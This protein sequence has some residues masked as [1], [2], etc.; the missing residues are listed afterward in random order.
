FHPAA[1]F[2]QWRE[3]AFLPFGDL[4]GDGITDT[5]AGSTAPNP[6]ATD[7]IASHA[8]GPFLDQGFPRAAAPASDPP[9]S[10]TAIA[11]SGRD[12]H[13]IWKTELDPHRI[14]YER[15]HGQGY[16]LTAHPLPAGDLDGDGTP[17]VI[18][19]KHAVRP[20][21][22]EIKP[23][24]TLPLQVLS[25]RTGRRLW[26]AGPLPLGFEAYGYSHIFWVKSLAITPND[27]P[28]LLV[29]HRSPFLPS[30]PLTTPGGGPTMP[31]LARVSGRDG[32]ILWDLALS[33]H[34]DP[35]NMGQLPPPGVGDLDGDG[36]LDVVVPLQGSPGTGRPDH[37]LKAVALRDGRLLWSHRLDYKTS[38]MT[39]PQ[40]AVADLDGDT[41]AEVLVTEQ[42]AAG[43]QAALG[44]KAL[45][46]RDGEVRW[47]WKGTP[48]IPNQVWGWL[49]LADFQ[50]N[51]RHTPCLGFSDPND[52]K[53]V[54]RILVFDA[55]GEVSVHRD[56]S[57]NSSGPGSPG[58]SVT[59]LRAVDLTGDRRD[60][61]LLT[62][63]DRLHV[64]GRD[65]KELWSRPQK[66]NTRV[67]QILPASSGQAGTVI[68]SPAVGLDGADGHPRWAGHSP[69]SWWWSHFKPG[70]LDP[71][72]SSRPPLLIAQGLGTT[73][74]R[75]A[76]STTPKGDFASPRG[77][78]VPPG[79]ARDDPRWTRPL[80]WTN[81]VAREAV[82]PGLLA[83]VA[84]ALLNVG[85][86]LV[87]LRLAA[88]R[89][90]WTLRLLMA[91]PVAAAIPLTAFL[92]LEPLIPSLPAP[93]PSSAKTLYTLGTLAGIPVVAYPI[94]VG[95]S[96]I[97]R[98]WRGLAML[99]GLTVAVS[100]AIGLTWLRVGMR[101]MPAIE[102]YTWSE[103]YA[104]VL[105]GAYAVGFLFVSD[106][107]IRGVTRWVGRRGRPER[108]EWRA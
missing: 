71:G 55:Q 64:W 8:L 53:G 99:A 88:R 11:R 95:W 9:G 45:E 40:L 67:E 106:K 82:L 75:A 27:P 31:R 93:F 73:V 19:Q 18:V 46:G 62:Y 70:L 107:T 58:Y 5:L 100:L 74:C 17:D 43:D 13:V 16:N 37:E 51:G 72:D 26:S 69:H 54:S 80:P 3:D 6:S 25:G 97:R 33:E 22:L 47:T 102:H 59:D 35:M 57:Q 92:A 68:V 56:L 91:L 1:A 21:D 94:L 61:L 81:L 76:L 52:G 63:G 103:W 50:G 79:L 66:D 28:D 83:V 85:L 89:R 36:A 86:P 65:L 23:T 78:P 96:L 24:A 39:T 60:E 20:G 44:L 32:R 2:P 49:V 15:D 104:I 4:D 87:I 29:R 12:G 10:R 77:A 90:P 42:P 84:L 14:W 48:E 41:R 30:R 98:N 108:M 101:A 34:Q 105:P 38:F 7:A